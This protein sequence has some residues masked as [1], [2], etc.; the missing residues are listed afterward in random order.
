MTSVHAEHKDKPVEFFKWLRHKVAKTKEKSLEEIFRSTPGSKQRE[1][2]ACYEMAFQIVKTLKPHTIGK[3]LIKPCLEIF[4]ETVQNSESAAEEVTTLPLS[5]D[6]V[7]RRIDELP[8]DLEDQLC[9]ILNGTK[10]SDESTVKDSEALLLAF[11]VVPG[12]KYSWRE[13]CFVNRWKLRR[14]GRTLLKH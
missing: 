10:F 5:N 6:T 3:D 12:T 14:K 1:V 13:C 7:R 4:L 11:L 9:D 2:K 8:C